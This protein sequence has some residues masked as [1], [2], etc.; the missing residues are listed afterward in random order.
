MNTYLRL[1]LIISTAII[2]IGMAVFL[3]RTVN[4]HKFTEKKISLYSYKSKGN[5]SYKVLLLPNEIYTVNSLGEG[6]TYITDY[7]DHINAS[8]KYEFNGERPAEIKGNYEIVAVMEGMLGDEK[9]KK[10]VWKKEKTLQ[11]KTNFSVNDKK[12]SVQQDVPIKLKEYSDITQRIFKTSNV[13]FDTKLTILFKINLEAKTDK[14]VIKESLS[15]SMEIPLNSKSFEIKG[16]LSQGKEAAIEEVK[17]IPVPINHK[18]VGITSTIIGICVA[19]LIFLFLFTAELIINN[20]FKKKLDQ[21]FKLHGSRMVAI[22]SEVSFS[23]ESIMKVVSIEDL[24]RISDDMCKPILY[25]NSGDL[26]ELYKFYV[27]DDSKIYLF[28]LEEKLLEIVSVDKKGEII[29][30]H[31]QG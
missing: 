16:N 5:I 21:I 29:N 20:P 18:M 14:G 1:S 10:T 9:G 24:V 3:Y 6:N 30:E 22:E 28:E 31:L 11:I 25:R 19:L 23:C 2:I 17:K 26:K 13:N 4:E 27:I 8:I 7:I 15:P 12:Y